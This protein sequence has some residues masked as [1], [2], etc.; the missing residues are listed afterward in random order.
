MARV[1]PKP[2]LAFRNNLFRVTKHTPWKLWKV[3]EILLLHLDS[4]C[5]RFPFRHPF[6]RGFKLILQCDFEKVWN[7][8]FTGIC[9]FFLTLK[10]MHVFTHFA[11]CSL[12][13]C[14]SVL[15]VN[16]LLYFKLAHCLWNHL[17]LTI[18]SQL[19]SFYTLM[20]FLAFNSLAF[21]AS[22]FVCNNM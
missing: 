4:I 9:V 3:E 21:L 15:L 2:S 7:C 11:F 22:Q 14:W 16:E 6:M 10:E 5:K 8:H 12:H 20:L 19:L 17:H 13:C 18:P 1:A